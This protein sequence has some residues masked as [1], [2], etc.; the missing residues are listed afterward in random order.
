MVRRHGSTAQVIALG[1]GINLVE[2][3]GRY[4]VQGLYSGTD[5][6]PINPYL[7]NNLN[8]RMIGSLGFER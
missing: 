6:T 3:E 7:L 2:P 1:E 8:L 4:V 5:T